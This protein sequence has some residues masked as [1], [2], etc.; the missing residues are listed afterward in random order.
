MKATYNNQIESELLGF[1][2]RMAA[3]W[4][5]TKNSQNSEYTY[6]W[7]I[8]NFDFAMEVGEGKIESSSFCIP[9]V[10][11]EFQIV[12][13]KKEEPF[14]Y[15]RSTSYQMPTR[16]KVNDIDNAKEFE[17]KFYFS[18]S[19]KSTVEDTNAAG[20]L[21]IIK[22]GAETQSGEFGDV[23]NHKF[24][25]S[26]VFRPKVAPKYYSTRAGFA[27]SVSGGGFYTRGSTCKLNLVAQITIPGKLTSLGG[28]EEEEMKQNRLM[29][30][31]Q[32]FLSD[33]KHS[34]IVLKCGDIRFPC[35]KLLLAARY[36]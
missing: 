36:S 27:D 21:E 34:D 18:V 35:H 22:E 16:L 7:A 25:L 30:D 19:M 28:T 10:S 9:G 26:Y 11:A 8:E 32:P 1:R 14:F 24:A 17:A 33:P 15:H 5:I 31:F 20:K 2:V 23:A 13:E 4:G 6:K 12:V 29:M 3:G